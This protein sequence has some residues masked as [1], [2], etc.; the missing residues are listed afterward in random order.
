ME[1]SGFDWSKARGIPVP[2]Y[3]WE[4]G[5]PKEFYETFVKT[6]H[7]V[8]LRGFLKGTEIMDYNFENMMSL[9][10]D[11][12]VLLANPEEQ[13]GYKGKLRDVQNPKIYLH[14]SEILFN[15]YPA[16]WKMLKT[17]RLEPYM[18]KKSSFA[19][20]FIGRGGTGAPFHNA[21]GWNFFYMV[22]GVKRW[23]F[24]DPYDFYLAYPFYFSGLATA[25]LLALY[26]DKYDENAMP[27]FK[28]C[29]YYVTEL[30]PG[31]V[32]LN[33]AWWAHGIKNITDKS[34]GVATRWTTDGVVGN[35]LT[36]ME[37]DYNI[38]R[39]NSLVH[40][41]GWASVR[42]LQSILATPVPKFDEHVTLRETKTT[43]FLSKQKELAE[44]RVKIG[45]WRPMF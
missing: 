14:N 15:K 32:L 28:Y 13:D 41:M 27:A 24:V 16:F 4:N 35:T 31:D 34:V 5:N 40:Q 22:D 38:Q 25:L 26:P 29:P 8:V 19:Q 11:E 45:N 36:T 20:F 39:V 21:N 18:Q 2:E 17:D 43:R 42:L 37:E 44:G 12:D 1:K 6:P 9:F 30:Q 10:G 23:H 7:P 33:P 3:D